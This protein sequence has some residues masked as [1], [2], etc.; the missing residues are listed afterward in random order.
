[1]NSCC[2][3]IT[4]KSFTTAYF[5]DLVEKHKITHV[6]MNASHLAEVALL[7]DVTKA[8]EKM[9]SIVA[10]LAGGSVMP[11]IVHERMERMIPNARE[12]PGF[13]AAYGMSELA[14]LVSMNGTTPKQRCA[15]SVGQLVSNRIVRIIDDKGMPLGPNEL[16][17]IC[18]QL[19]QYSWKGYFKNEVATKRALVDNWLHTGDMGHF[20]SQGFLH[21]C[22]RGNDVFKSRNFQIYPQILEGL[23]AKVPGVFDVCVVGIPNILATNL[24]AAAV[25]RTA[26]EEGQRLT[27]KVIDDHVKANIAEMYNLHGGVYFFEALP[28]TATGKMLRKTIMD[29]VVKRSKE[30]NAVN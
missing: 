10:L 29:M 8:H 15:S 17:Q 25:V 27:A 2:R 3:I 22:S 16:G 20:D 26:D 12:R 24:T 9:K 23:I 18:I 14:G 19:N 21:F 30:E 28:K 6:I 4:E 1:M 13:M 7:E 5:L 11:T